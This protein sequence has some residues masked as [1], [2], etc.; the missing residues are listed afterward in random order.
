M[1]ENIDEFSIEMLYI[2]DLKP[3]VQELL[4]LHFPTLTLSDVIFIPGY[5]SLYDGDYLL[6][7]DNTLTADMLCSDEAIT[8]ELYQRGRIKIIASNFAPAIF[9]ANGGH[10]SGPK[11]YAN[12]IH[13]I[14][15]D[16]FNA[17]INK[18][19]KE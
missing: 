8:L 3:K 5:G 17:F 1:N 9:V 19:P 13:A 6:L 12:S 15:N 14:T 11:E 16:N 10:Y 18:K 4:F 2:K 7:T